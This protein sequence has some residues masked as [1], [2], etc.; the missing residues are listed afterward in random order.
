[1]TLKLPLLPTCAFVVALAF[2][3]FSLMNN[4]LSWLWLTAFFTATGLFIL[5]HDSD[6]LTAKFA[7]IF[8]ALLI[9]GVIGVAAFIGFVYYAASHIE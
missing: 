8:F 5:S 7:R 3:C 6:K 9:I 2:A 1:M 4:H